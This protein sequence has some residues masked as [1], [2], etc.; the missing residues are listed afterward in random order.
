MLN[1][2]KWP[3]IFVV[4]LILLKTV[5]YNVPELA[6][7][8]ILGIGYFGLGYILGRVVVSFLPR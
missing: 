2:L 4:S 7:P 8:V 5:E 1:N 6:T 3:L